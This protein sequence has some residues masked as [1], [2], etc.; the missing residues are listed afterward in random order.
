MTFE[1]GSA[2]V[3]GYPFLG[4]GASGKNIENSSLTIKRQANT[5]KV[6]ISGVSEYATFLLVYRCF[7]FST[8]H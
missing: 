8:S 5:I 7:F 1:D 6:S 4:H 2:F 3:V